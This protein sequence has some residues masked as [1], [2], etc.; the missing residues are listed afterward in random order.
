VYA[1]STTF[2][3]R[4]GN[5]DAGITF[6]KDE[7]WPMLE[8][9]EG[10]RGLSL[11][12]DRDTGHC[13]ATSSWESEETMHAS[14]EQLRPIRD[15][16]RDILGG[17][18]EMDEWE[19]AIMHRSQHGEACRVS[20]LQGDVDALTDSMRGAILPDLEH[21]PG[22]CGASVLINRSGGLGVATTVWETRDAMQASRMSA[23]EMRRR[24]A[25]DSGGEIMDVHEFD[26][27][28]AHLHVP[29]LA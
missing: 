18:M 27:A 21:T 24:A 9:I 13:I 16:G 10:C 25:S 23:D 5:I 2:H 3:G 17:T 4:P 28:Y 20:W 11:L 1:R 26:L 15:Q 12:V 29:E 7:V 19:V 8:A 14:D 6:I 22:F